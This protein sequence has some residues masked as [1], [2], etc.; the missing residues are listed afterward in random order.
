MTIEELGLKP[1][2][3]LVMAI[4]SEDIKV[5]EYIAKTHPE[6][7]GCVSSI[8]PLVEYSEGLASSP[9]G[10]AIVAKHVAPMFRYIDLIR[11]ADVFDLIAM[12]IGGSVYSLDG[13]D[14]FAV[15]GYV[16]RRLDPEHVN[17][18]RSDLTEYGEVD[19]DDVDLE[20]YLESKRE[21]AFRDD[22]E[23]GWAVIDGYDVMFGSHE[24]TA[25]EVEHPRV[26]GT[27]SI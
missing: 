25:W 9:I 6:A 10:V 27:D 7:T 23:F 3:I 22:V 16:S 26:N 19:R 20:E 2:D 5:V 4:C 24:I 12:Q 18:M 15:I 1:E 11:D 14:A 13:A 8:E 21:G 17:E